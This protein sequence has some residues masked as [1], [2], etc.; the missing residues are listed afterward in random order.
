M[1]ECSTRDWCRIGDILIEE[2]SRCP[3]RYQDQM[4]EVIHTIQDCIDTDVFYKV[5]KFGIGYQLIIFDPHK[6]K[7]CLYGY[8]LTLCGSK[9]RLQKIRESEI[10]YN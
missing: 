9:I 4:D 1:I 10:K 3:L 6:F 2:A 7:G 8:I 5:W